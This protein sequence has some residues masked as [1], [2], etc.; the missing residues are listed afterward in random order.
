MKDD[1]VVLD[2]GETWTSIGESYVMLN[3]TTEDNQYFEQDS[4]DIVTVRELVEFWQANK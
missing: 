3:A 1:I 2:D 4:G